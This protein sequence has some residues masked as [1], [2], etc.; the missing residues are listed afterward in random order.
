MVSAQT[1]SDERSLLDVDDGISFSKDDL[2]KLNLRFRMQNRLGLYSR[3]GDDL[4]VERVEAMVRRLRLR[5]DGYVLSPKISY[6]IQLSFSKG[7]QD[8]ENGVVPQTVRDAILYY[9][10]NKNFYIGFGQSK[11]PGNRQR[12]IS[13][14]NQQFAERSFANARMNIDRDFGLFAYYTL[15]PSQNFIVNL[16]GAITTGD[17]RNASISNNGMAYTGRIELLP[18]GNFMDNGDYS[19]GDLN[20]EPSPKLSIAVSNSINKRAMRT[21]GQLG[22]ELYNERDIETLIV[23]G[24]FKYN[25]WAATGEYFKRTT[26]N[27]SPISENVLGDKRFVTTGQAFNFQG[28]RMLST[29]TELA[30]RYTFLDTDEVISSL[31]PDRK[32]VLIGSSRYLNGHRIKLQSFLGYEWLPALA[33]TSSKDDF[34]VLMMQIEFGI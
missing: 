20:F 3:A 11:L 28:S 8:L 17:G 22:R 18:F 21:G 31:E 14:G 19:E 2:F 34:W 32:S 29:K 27:N 30:M 5:F 23:D 1:E 12:V 24:V 25:G 13:S 4:G 26:P 16:K 6:Y 7:D 33:R 15:V 10:F 9:T